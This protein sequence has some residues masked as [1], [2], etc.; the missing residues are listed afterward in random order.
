MLILNP[1]DT[2]TFRLAL[3][4]HS[5]ITFVHILLLSLFTSLW[6]HCLL[7]ILEGVAHITLYKLLP[8]NGH[9]SFAYLT[10]FFCGLTL[11]CNLPTLLTLSDVIVN[12][13]SF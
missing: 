9:E 8:D 12:S 2:K 1:K 5:V 3:V 13:L 4:L 11:V 7:I 10:S 6:V